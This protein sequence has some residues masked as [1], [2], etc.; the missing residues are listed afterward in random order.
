MVKILSAKTLTNPNDSKDRFIEIQLIPNGEK[1]K[2]VWVNPTNLDHREQ[3]PNIK[4]GSEVF[5]LCDELFNYYVIGTTQQGIELVDKKIYKIENSDEIQILTDKKL[6]IQN[7]AGNKIEDTTLKTKK[8]EVELDKFSI[9]NS[10]TEWVQTLS[11]TLQA[12]IDLEI[13]GNLGQPA[14]DSPTTKQKF[15][16]LKARIDSFKQ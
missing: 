2:A 7:I 4:V 9:T 3:K 6:T 14:Y 1:V 8:M 16:D 11:D 10:T 5:V 13:V 12:L 15:I